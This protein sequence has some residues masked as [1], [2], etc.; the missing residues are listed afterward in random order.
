MPTVYH[1][2][3]QISLDMQMEEDLRKYLEW[4]SGK[5][6][7]INV[8]KTNYMVFNPK[9]KP[10]IN[11]KLEINSIALAKKKYKTFGCSTR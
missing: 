10:D 9:R 3:S 4:L 5:E 1:S 11:L 6:L 7:I 2:N 8:T